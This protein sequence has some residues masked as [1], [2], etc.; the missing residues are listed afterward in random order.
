MKEKRSERGEIPANVRKLLMK[1]RVYVHFMRD[2]ETGQ[3]MEIR[4]KKM[5][6]SNK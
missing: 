2:V 6:K 1:Y 3:V 4:K 5:I